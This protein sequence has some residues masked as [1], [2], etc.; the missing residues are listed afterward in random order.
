MYLFKSL[1]GKKPKAYHLKPSENEASG[2]LTTLKK[3]KK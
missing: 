2:F 3:L 1:L